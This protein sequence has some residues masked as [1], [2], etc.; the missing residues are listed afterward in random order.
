M[1]KIAATCR[2]VTNSN[3]AMPAI[4]TV[5][6]HPVQRGHVQSPAPDFAMKGMSMRNRGFTLLELLVVVGVL[7]L[8]LAIILPALTMFKHASNTA[9]CASNLREMGYHTTSF[10]I[11]NQGKC[12]PFAWYDSVGFMWINRLVPYGGMDKARFCPE[13]NSSTDPNGP[14]APGGTQNDG[15]AHSAWI[16]TT[17]LTT[18]FTNGYIQPSDIA[19]WD[20]TINNPSLKGAVPVGSYGINGWCFS[21]STGAGESMSLHWPYITTGN[22]AKIPL[23]TDAIWVDGLPGPT[24]APPADPAVGANDGGMGRYCLARHGFAI[25]VV[26]VDN[27]VERV[28]LPNL[29][30]MSWSRQAGWPA[31]PPMVPQPSSW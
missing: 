21:S 22:S 1:M 24:S 3:I 30:T 17:P 16:S 27:H 20:G 14:I 18:P 4:P 5:F 8:L 28:Q 31:T 29:W 26:F 15:T 9:I 11:D 23:F 10:A 25:N 12:L 2:N 6:P 19:Y 7:V 13:A